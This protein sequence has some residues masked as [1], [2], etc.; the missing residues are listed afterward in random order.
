MTFEQLER[1]L[2]SDAYD[3]LD[4]T[5]HQVDLQGWVNGGFGHAFSDAIKGKDKP[6]VVEVGTYKG[7]SA[8]MMADIMNGQG[9]ILCVDTWLGAPEFWTHERDMPKVNGWPVIFY[10]FT[11]NVKTLGLQ[12]VITPFPISSQQAAD[13]LKY[14]GVQAD[15]IYIDASHE[16]EA[17]LSDLKAWWPV[18]KPGGVMIGDDYD[19]NC[20]QG[21]VRAVNE[22][23]PEGRVMYDCVWCVKKDQA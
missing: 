19:P 14:Y 4:V 8:V 21:V 5:G 22:F 23:F 7:K 12:N 17:V 1:Q 9:K 13:V 15:V 16:Y 3:S 20:H 10:K 6:F 18:L 11:K 2:S